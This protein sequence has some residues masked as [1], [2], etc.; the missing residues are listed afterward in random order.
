MNERDIDL[1]LTA[2]N[3]WSIGNIAI[4]MAVAAVGLALVISFVPNFSE[5]AKYL[6]LLAAIVG[7]STYGAGHRSYV[8][9]KDLLALIERNINA[10]PSLIS[11]VSSRQVRRHTPDANG[12]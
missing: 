1:Y 5:Y 6:L 10:D 11:M 9:R 8:S 2:K 12:S 7:T 3:P 4:N